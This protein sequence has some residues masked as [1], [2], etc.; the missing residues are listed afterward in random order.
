[1][2]SEPSL[3]HPAQIGGVDAPWHTHPG[4]DDDRDQHDEDA[5]D[6]QHLV[7]AAFTRRK[8]FLTRTK[9]G[10]R[11]PVTRVLPE[12]RSR[13]RITSRIASEIVGAGGLQS[14]TISAG[15]VSET[16]ARRAHPAK[17]VMP[18]R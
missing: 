18:D 7:L 10:N 4:N 6:E 16:T 14:R 15:G 1:M 17:D 11:R 12:E 5:D 8:D 9:D 3:A 13:Q 2:F